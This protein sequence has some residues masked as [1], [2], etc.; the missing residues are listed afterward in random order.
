MAERHLGVL[1]AFAC[2]ALGCSHGGAAVADVPA[3]AIEP[4]PLPPA[5]PPP[6]EFVDAYIGYAPMPE[7]TAAAPSGEVWYRQ[8]AIRR[9]GKEIFLYQSAVVCRKGE[10]WASSSDGG[11]YWYRG[12]LEGVAPDQRVRLVL[13]HC[14][15]CIEPPGGFPMAAPQAIAFPDPRTV[16][17]DGVRHGKDTKPYSQACPAPARSPPQAR[18]EFRTF[19]SL[20]GSRV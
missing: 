19:T 1:G 12:R 13:D 16:V 17:L 20:P 7:F 14:D 10:L 15:Y 2:L 5:P 4:R 6:A 3:R 18:V 8:N 11:F 9:V